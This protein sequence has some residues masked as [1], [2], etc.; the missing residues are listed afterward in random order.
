MEQYT[1][2]DKEV[3]KAFME[4][5]TLKSYRCKSDGQSFYSGELR[6]AE[7]VPS[8]NGTASTLVYDFTD[9]GGFFIDKQVQWHVIQLKRSAP[10]QNVVGIRDAQEFGLV[11]EAIV[12]GRNEHTPRQAR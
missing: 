10:R 7:H 8:G 2:D 9:R 5:R 1:N 11:D 6:V 4:C 3:V 12:G